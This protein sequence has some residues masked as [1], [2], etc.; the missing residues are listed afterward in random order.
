MPTDDESKMIDFFVG[1]GCEPRLLAMTH[2]TP[3]TALTRSNI[4]S[5]RKHLLVS[6]NNELP[7]PGATSGSKFV[8][9]VS[10]ATCSVLFRQ[11]QPRMS[12]RSP[13]PLRAAYRAAAS[14]AERLD[15]MSLFC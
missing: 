8:A 10:E 3:V 11:G 5:A 2:Q 14:P 12:L 7:T 9:R 15:G 6:L 13:G 4:G 1:V